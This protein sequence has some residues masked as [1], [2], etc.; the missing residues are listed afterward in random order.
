MW[1]FTRQT[2][3]SPEAE[4]AKRAAEKSLHDAQAHLPVVEAKLN[5]SR[6]V[7]E[8]LSAHNRA[9]RYSDWIEAVV[10]GRLSDG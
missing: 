2:Q 3:V 6:R 5:E 7:K 10:L 4:T 9:N 1:P 8:Q